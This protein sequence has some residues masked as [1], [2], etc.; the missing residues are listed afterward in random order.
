MNCSTPGFPVLY[1][2]LELAQTHVHWVMMPSNHLILCSLLLLMPSIFAS[3]RVFSNE[4]A[5]AWHGLSTGASA[6]A[7]VLP[8]T[9]QGWFPLGL[10]GMISLLSQGLS[11]LFPLLWP[12][13]KYSV[14][15]RLMRL[16]Q[17]YLDTLH[18]LGWL[19]GTSVT[20][21]ESLCSCTWISTV[22]ISRDQSPVAHL[23]ILPTNILFS[24]DF[25]S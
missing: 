3:I 13:R 21:A 2:L 1:H 19:T 16:G 22:L 9:S 10:T 14:F 7:S 8:M 18:I 4:L 6:S 20:S 25:S 12:A 23:R 15:N 24:C 17:A 5:L 11:Q